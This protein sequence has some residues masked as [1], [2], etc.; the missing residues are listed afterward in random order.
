MEE[1][2]DK[3]QLLHAIEMLLNDVEEIKVEAKKYRSKYRLRYQNTK[4]DAEIRRYAAK[5][6]VNDFS[7]KSAISGGATALTGVIPGMGTVI[8]A[9][10]GTLADSALAMKYDIEM[11]LS[12]ATLYDYDISEEKNFDMAFVLAGLGVIVNSEGKGIDQYLKMA[13][14]TIGRSQEGIIANVF[15]HVSVLLAKKAL[16]K[17]IPLGIGVVLSATANKKQGYSLGKSAVAYFEENV[18]ENR[19]KE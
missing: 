16:G 5:A 14:A 19:N 10:G 3:P 7:N 17:A 4:S 13:K 12:L 1:M 6:I 2:K 9:F 11:M 15:K 18:E 8:A